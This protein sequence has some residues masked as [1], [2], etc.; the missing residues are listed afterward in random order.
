MIKLDMVKAKL[1][2]NTFRQ[3]KKKNILIH[4]TGKLFCKEKTDGTCSKCP[5]TTS[6]FTCM[7]FFNVDD[8]KVLIFELLKCFCFIYEIATTVLI[9]MHFYSN[10]YQILAC[11]EHYVTLGMVPFDLIK[12]LHANW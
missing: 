3:K 11:N 1:R 9:H 12:T 2:R 8:L 6:R 10:S 5:W 4:L 7:S